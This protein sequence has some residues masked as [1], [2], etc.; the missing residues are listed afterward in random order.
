MDQSLRGSRAKNKKVH[1][2]WKRLVTQY[3]KFDG[4]ISQREEF[5]K[6]DIENCHRANNQCI[7]AWHDI[8]NG[9]EW[10]NYL[11]VM[12]A[13]IPYFMKRYGNL[14]RYSNQ[15]WEALNQKLKAF[16]FHNTNHGGANGRTGESSGDHLLPLM[17]MNQRFTGWL[18]GIGDEFFE[19]IE[20]GQALETETENES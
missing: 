20:D 1:G 16:Y 15:G 3:R 17:R 10:T 6:N 13:H 8:T 11:H 7:S 5:S 14:Y 9:S 12:A 18:L 4:I 2:L 19:A